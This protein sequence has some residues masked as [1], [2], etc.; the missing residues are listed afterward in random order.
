MKLI[1]S[2]FYGLALLYSSVS[3]AVQITGQAE[4]Q[5]IPLGESIT[6]TLTADEHLADDALDI[7]PLFKPTFRS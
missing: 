1:Y 4:P 2:G 5:R 6:Y 7:R 3:F